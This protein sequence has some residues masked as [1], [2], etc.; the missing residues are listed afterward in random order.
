M[1]KIIGVMGDTGYGKSL[2]PVVPPDGIIKKDSYG[3]LNLDETVIFNL[4]DKDLPFETYINL[5]PKWKEIFGD[6]IEKRVLTPEIEQ[7]IPMLKKVLE[8]KEIKNIII[9]TLSLGMFDYRMKQEHVKGFEKWNKLNIDFWNI[10]N[11]IRKDKKSD[12][13]VW[14]FYHIQESKDREGNTVYKT[15]TEGNLLDKIPEKITTNMFF[16]TI[17]NGKYVFETQ[18]NGT[19]AKNPP[20]LFD[21]KIPNSL[22][23]IED[24][25]RG[26]K[27]YTT[28]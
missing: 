14:I 10:L 2:S 20:L 3:G 4:D 15:K 9:D 25:L 8:K 7:F 21:F 12:K 6:F 1:A 13:F 11:K 24:T 22:K 19:T 16:A 26:K 17:D 18:S 5:Y 27:L 23:L 28:K